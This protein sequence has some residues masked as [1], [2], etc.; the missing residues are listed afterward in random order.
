MKTK[1]SVLTAL[2]VAA[3]GATSAMA[4]SQP[5][6]REEVK[7]ELSRAM[8]SG[9][10][11]QNDLNYGTAWATT[12]SS[13]NYDRYVAG[14]MSG[15]GMGDSSMGSSTASSSSMPSDSSSLGAAGRSYDGSTSGGPASRADVAADR[16]AAMRSDRWIFND[17][18]GV[19]RLDPGENS[20][21]GHVYMGPAD[22]Y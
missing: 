7:A 20:H 5:L 13:K 19:R 8:S 4:Q 12:P 15:S 6:T 18:D 1:L 10:I 21:A 3:L 2:V 17:L 16:D 9:G 14:T 22:S 11:E